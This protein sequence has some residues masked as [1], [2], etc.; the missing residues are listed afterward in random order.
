M[1]SRGLWGSRSLEFWGVRIWGD[2]VLGEGDTEKEIGTCK[3]T[4]GSRPLGF[5]HG[6]GS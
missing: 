2:G 3:F 5:K 6:A 4:V 1:M